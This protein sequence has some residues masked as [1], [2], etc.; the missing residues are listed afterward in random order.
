MQ[1]AWPEIL[2]FPLVVQD[3]TVFLAHPPLCVVLGAAKDLRLGALAGRC[4]GLCGSMGCGVKI[5]IYL[6]HDAQEHRE[7]ALDLDQC[8]RFDVTEDSPYF[9]ALDG[10]RFVNH[11]L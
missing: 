7:A 11:D 2:H 8:F 10:E 1:G 6:F 5:A 3:D 9:V 4:R